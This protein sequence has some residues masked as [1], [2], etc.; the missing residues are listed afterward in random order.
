MVLAVDD[1]E[2]SLLLLTQ[3][4]EL[5]GH[6]T[7]AAI[8]GETAL[9]LAKAFCPDLILLDI[10][11]PDISGFTVLDQ[12]KQNR[13]TAAIPVVAVTALA[14]VEDQARLLQAGCQACL[15]KPYLLEDLDAIVDHYLNPARVTC[16]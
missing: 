15:S 4:L 10:V 7:I 1:E 6:S 11:L 8:D 9:A 13:R 2:D 12:L 14:A 3:T 5:S 16:V